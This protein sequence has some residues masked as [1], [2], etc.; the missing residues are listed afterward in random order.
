MVRRPKL[1]LDTSPR[2]L[3]PIIL[4]Q[5]R[6]NPSNTDGQAVDS[7]PMCAKTIVMG[8]RKVESDEDE[9]WRTVVK[10]TSRTSVT[11]TTRVAATTR[12]KNQ[13]VDDSLQALLAATVA[14]PS[15]SSNTQAYTSV[16]PAKDAGPGP[17]APRKRVKKEAAE[18]AEEKRLA[19]IRKSCPKVC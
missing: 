16:S 9:D 10:K 12:V 7:V 8:K 17:S 13:Q 15:S 18:P 5:W 19:R 6:S 4:L 2:R 1:F 11:R 3:V 14:G